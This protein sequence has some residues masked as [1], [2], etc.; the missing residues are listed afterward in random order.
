[1]ENNISGIINISKPQEMTS[2]DVVAIVRRLIGVKR[3]GH[4]GTLDPMATGVL[5]VCVGSATRIMEYLDL[6]LKTYKC[7]MKL[8][9][10][11]DT[12]DIWGEVIGGEN[13][14]GITED[15]ICEVVSHYGGIINQIPP[16]YS[17]LKV[18]G[19]KLYE[20]ARANVPVEIKSRKVM[21]TELSLDEINGAEIALTITCSKGTYIRSICRDI[22]EEL[23]CG[24]CMSFLERTKS[25][26]FKI[27]DAITIDELRNMSRDEIIAGLL[28][29]EYPLTKLGK[30]V[31]N[32]KRAGWFLNGGRLRTAEVEIQ[33]TAVGDTGF[34][35]DLRSDERLLKAY[36]IFDGE[37][38]LGVAVKEGDEFKPDKIFTTN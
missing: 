26:E 7:R 35:G 1:M 10:R 9:M 11:T 14:E 15:Q 30:A 4:T 2:H 18:N 32:P 3:V 8:G 5:A 36:R 29:A 12:D 33:Q 16:R 6:D 22:G 13:P 34:V 38:F 27:E 23:G 20:Y 21:I 31:V 28:P 37:R 25:G 17:A 19:R 24:G